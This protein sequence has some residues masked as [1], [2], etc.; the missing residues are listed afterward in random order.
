MEHTLRTILILATLMAPWALGD[1]VTR[2][3]KGT[4]SQTASA[5][6][7][8]RSSL[9]T[10][11]D[12]RVL[13]SWTEQTPFGMTLWYAVMSPTGHI[14]HQPTQV[15]GLTGLPHR[16]RVAVSG[17]VFVMVWDEDDPA[18]LQRR[19]VFFQI[20]DFMGTPQ[21]PQA[22][23]ANTQLV[24]SAE[25]PSVAG[26]PDGSFALA[27][28]RRLPSPLGNSEGVYLRRF[29]QGGN[30]QDTVE[31]RVDQPASL[32]FHQ[33][34]TALAAWPSGRLAVAWQD[35]LVGAAPGTPLAADGE[36]SAI[37]ARVLLPSLGFTTS[38][39][40]LVNSLT[41]GDQQEPEV[42][43]SFFNRCVIGW[44]GPNADGSSIKVFYRRMN[45]SGVSLDPADVMVTGSFPGDQHITGLGMNSSG[46][47]ALSWTQGQAFSSCANGTGVPVRVARFGAS[48]QPLGIFETEPPGTP[49]SQARASLSMD[50]WGNTCLA[51]ETC[52]PGSAFV[53]LTFRRFTRHM[54]VFSG[55][56]PAPGETVSLMIDSPSDPNH[57][58]ILMASLGFGPIPLGLRNIKLDPDF[59][60]GISLFT[61]GFGVLNGFQGLLDSQGLSSVPSATIPNNPSL[62]GL[63]INFA[64]MAGGTT[65]LQTI[66]DT[67]TLTIR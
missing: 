4:L 58:F 22:A 53:Q 45:D 55:R 50:E 20:L 35:G 37:F 3:R 48:G 51:Y 38:Q 21:L 7:G 67:Y 66:S 56:N 59:V 41:A 32:L 2:G 24:S 57:V 12:G 49:G 44:H 63:S 1:G 18:L 26:F 5:L 42:S 61:T 13:V 11:P 23:L 29:G 6:L 46:E 64:F 65:H 17:T 28:I 14:L 9:A 25:E 52:T 40:I 34:F 36:G 54:I 43:A 60:L 39:N 27:W 19:K 33:H 62:R 31:V 30:P 10:A 8:A 47:F 16:V 15:T